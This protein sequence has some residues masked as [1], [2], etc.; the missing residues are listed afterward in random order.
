MFLCCFLFSNWNWNFE[1]NFN[2]KPIQ[3]FIETTVKMANKIWL[4]WNW[5]AAVFGFFVV[6]DV[7]SVVVGSTVVD[8]VPIKLQ[9]SVSVQNEH[10]SWL[11]LQKMSSFSV[12]SDVQFWKMC[13]SDPWSIIAQE[14]VMF[15]QYTEYWLIDSGLSSVGQFVVA[16]LLHR[17]HRRRFFGNSPP[18]HDSS[19]PLAI[20]NLHPVLSCKQV[21][22][23]VEFVTHPRWMPP[24]D[25]FFDKLQKRKLF[26]KKH[27]NKFLCK[28]DGLLPFEKK[29]QRLWM[30]LL[31]IPIWWSSKNHLN[32]LNLIGIVMAER[33]RYCWNIAHRLLNHKRGNDASD[34]QHYKTVYYS[35]CISL[36][37]LNHIPA[38]P[39]GSTSQSNHV[40]AASL[41]KINCIFNELWTRI[42]KW[43][44]RKNW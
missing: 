36:P 13:C 2:E 7:G 31:S 8:C 25:L 40:S 5:L 3:Y 18:L 26:K 43:P 11:A 28:F 20:H 32:H 37:L 29:N 44:K 41:K 27:L 33:F 42:W 35:E 4:M 24:V 38:V 30:T 39:S 15:L 16:V 6:I 34:G 10:R 9:L 19:L 12:I 21:L 1:D 23:S 17:M 14:S 22:Y